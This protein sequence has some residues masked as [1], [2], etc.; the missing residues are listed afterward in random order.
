MREKKLLLILKR[1]TFYLKI[2]LILLYIHS[3]RKIHERKGP[4]SEL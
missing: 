2:L 1:E 3:N 4:K